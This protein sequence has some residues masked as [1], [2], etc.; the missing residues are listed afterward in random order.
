MRR[1]LA[2]VVLAATSLTLALA[3]APAAVNQRGDGWPRIN[4]MKLINANHSR[5]PLDARVGHDPFQGTDRKYR[6]DGQHAGGGCKRFLEKCKEGRGLCVKDMHVHNE[7][8]GGDN[9]D[10]I[11]GGAEGDVIWGDYNPSNPPGQVDKLTGGSGRDFIYGSKGKN[12]IKAGPGNDFVKARY[13][14]GR[15]DCGPGNDILYTSR[16][17]KKRYKI[18]HC[19]RQSTGASPGQGGS[20]TR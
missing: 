19:E 1:F 7:L 18:K 9:N 14:R 2:V 17:Y 6:C 20:P 3:V 11:Y 13:G 16:R 4:G 5:R 8:L 12:V 10:T 15:I